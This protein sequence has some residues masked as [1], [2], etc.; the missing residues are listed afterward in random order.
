MKRLL[1]TLLTMALLLAPCAVAHASQDQHDGAAAR[2]SGHNH[3]AGRGKHDSLGDQT[4]S[5]NS[6]APNQ[7]KQHSLT[8]GTGSKHSDHDGHHSEGSCLMNCQG[9]M[10][11]S[12]HLVLKRWALIAAGDIDQFAKLFAAKPFYLGADS[13]APIGD[14]PPFDGA[15]ILSQISILDRTA[16]RRI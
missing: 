12:S 14:S 8:V 16:R 6:W 13:L 5:I 7:R 11:A 10:S 4:H 2:Q 15:R 3:Q 1:T 9:W